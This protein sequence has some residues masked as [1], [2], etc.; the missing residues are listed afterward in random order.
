MIQPGNERFQFYV[1]KND[2]SCGPGPMLPDGSP[3][4]DYSSSVKAYKRHFFDSLREFGELIVL[5]DATPHDQVLQQLAQP[6]AILAYVHHFSEGRELLPRARL[7]LLHLSLGDPLLARVYTKKVLPSA[8]VELVSTESI[9]QGLQRV[10]R[11]EYPQTFVFAPQVDATF[12]ARPTASERAAAR[13]SYSLSP[14]ETHVIYVGRKIVTKGIC[15]L[16]RMLDAWPIP[17]LRLTVA[18]GFD[19]ADRMYTSV[20]SHKTFPE[21]F[22]TE[23][24]RGEERKWLRFVPH[25]DKEAL[26]EL[27]RS[28]DLYAYP[29]I[30]PDENFGISSWEA[31]VCGV[32]VVVTDFGGLRDLAAKMPWPGVPS[33]P[34]LDG[35]RFSLRAFHAT[36][37]RAIQTI[38]TTAL[39]A[40]YEAVRRE[41]APSANRSNLAA[42]LECLSQKEPESLL[43][44]GETQERLKWLLARSAP[45]PAFKLFAL[46][47]T[48]NTPPDPGMAVYGDAWNKPNWPLAYG[49]YSA[50]TMPPQVEARTSWRGFFRVALWPEEQCLVEFGFP[51]PRIRRYGPDDWES[52]RS[53]A[54]EEQSNDFVFVP[55]TPRQTQLLQ[56]LV[57]FGYLVDDSGRLSE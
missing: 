44:P 51:G 20:A 33:Y 52:L 37:L 45:W 15:Q 36:L 27:F 4:I 9:K 43:P 10:F 23:I 6:N 40:H 22:R 14:H 3:A 49:A 50:A 29:S 38:R 5:D 34:T 8:Q 12:F 46:R 53:C 2:Y 1:L 48:R 18:G 24:L 56:E 26:R 41:I 28:A 57:N 39:D 47:R 31:A 42:A 19:E 11:G 54:R 7:R 30:S 21:F 17:N 35:A 32:P 16:I 55:E 13:Q 25:L